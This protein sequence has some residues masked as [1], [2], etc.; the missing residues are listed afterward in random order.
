MRALTDLSI[1]WKLTLIIVCI[2]AAAVVMACGVM[3]GYDIL[4]L[5]KSMRTDL[6][7]LAEIVARNSTAALTFHDAHAAEDI[8]A[9]LKAKPHI[10][11]ACVYDENG[12]MFAKYVRDGSNAAFPAT[13][14]APGERFDSRRLEEVLLIRLQDESIGSVYVQSDLGEMYARLNR[15]G[16]MMVLVVLGASAVSFLLA[17]RFQQLI[18][19]PVLQLVHIMKKVSKEENYT[20]RA[21]V[22]SQDELGMLVYGFNDML[23]K[24]E[25]RDGQLQMQQSR[26]EQEVTSRT[27]ELVATNTHL[28]TAKDAAE[29]AN[30]AKS[31]FL[32]NMS[33]EIRTP[34]N[35]ILGMTELTLD[36]V[37][38]TEQQECLGMAKSSGEAL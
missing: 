6:A 24:I 23:S 1:R 10:A 28:I 30:R 36:T 2:S 37:L 34:I 16:I 25:Q 13:Y 14:P 32:A 20:L 17:S 38:T 26:S 27:A 18:S 31:E 29:E 12:R 21:P 19:A 5:R 7:T 9:A 15:Y 4:L 8:L 3:G 33:H 22:S 11:V 35:G